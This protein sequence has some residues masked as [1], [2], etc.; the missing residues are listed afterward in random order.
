MSQY[1]NFFPKTVYTLDDSSSLD[2]VTNL[3]SSF[4][5]G[6]DLTENYV[7]YYTY[8]I[9]DGET[10]ENLAYK[11]YGSVETHWIIMKM[12]NMIDMKKDWPL[13]QRSLIRAIDEK[14]SAQGALVQQTGY[15]W[16]KS[17]IH[18]YYKIETKTFTST[19]DE[20]V[21]MIAIDEET[22][23]S[24]QNSTE[25]YTLKDGNVLRI[26]I[27]K[28]AKTYYDYEVDENEKK[29]VIKILKPEFVP[30]LQSEFLATI[31]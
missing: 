8:S 27:T 16:S 2:T 12:N 31:R 21:D 9:S 24:L 20:T 10:P 14:Y 17:N 6:S 28:T 19:G 3:T 4:S 13:E 18:S 26:D 15:Q 11:L 7:V 1:F 5:I 23:N 29:R 25:T 30:A 22:Y